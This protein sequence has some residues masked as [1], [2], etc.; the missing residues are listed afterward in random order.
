MYSVPYGSSS[1]ERTSSR[2]TDRV[3]MATLILVTVAQLVACATAS[4]KSNLEHVAKD[5]SLTIRASQVIP[6]Y[7]L[8]ED[9]Q[10]GDVFLV[11]TPI[12]RQVD[13]YEQKGFLPIDQLVT[14]LHDLSY[15]HFYGDAYWKGTYAA[16]AHE[17]PGWPLSNAQQLVL[18]PR[19]AF[20]TY[21]FEV[22][23]ASGVQL[24][25][26][27]QGVPVGLGL[28]GAAQ[29]IG[30]V[31]IRDAYT[32]AIDQESLIR[33]FE[34]WVKS[35][36]INRILKDMARMGNTPTY[37]RAVHRVFLAQGVVVS[38]T[39]LDTQGAA[40]D[41]GAAQAVILP[42]LAVDRPKYARDAAKAYVAALN[43]LSG[44]PNK[45]QQAPPGGSFRFLQ[46]SRHAVTMQEDFDRPLAIGYL[47]FDVRVYRDGTVS[48]PLPSFDILAGDVGEQPFSTVPTSGS[49]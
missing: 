19:V 12:S 18:A 47:G 9:I 27:V 29:A 48:A 22:D 32:Y 3:A 11:N 38:L 31:T 46:A 35:P 21:N 28:M 49:F 1:R 23:Q 43:A 10:P 44:A 42:Q 7:P 16:T 26:P 4:L 39:N 37:L 2:M 34:K 17:R 8:T 6:V 30:T 25:L 45:L 15:K 14:R 20:P 13:L 36:D 40:M 5:W 24:A 33:R 41:A